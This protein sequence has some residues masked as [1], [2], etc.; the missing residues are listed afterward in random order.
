MKKISLFLSLTTAILISLSPVVSA[1]NS[2]TNISI[3]PEVQ[4]NFRSNYTCTIIMKNFEQLYDFKLI[5]KDKVD[6]NKIVTLQEEIS[7]LQTQINA[8]SNGEDITSKRE[9]LNAKL[10]EFNRLQNAAN[11]TNSAKFTCATKNLEGFLKNPNQT[12][13]CPANIENPAFNE[14]DILGCSIITGRIRFAYLPRFIVYSLDLL[15][16]LSGVVS[17]LFVILGGYF[18]LINGISGGDT[19]KGKTY[20][21]NALIGLITS[22]SAWAVINLIQLV[23]T[24]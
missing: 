11:P 20:I 17:L 5:T 13:Y 14:N 1:N 15:T 3:I 23:L 18:Y 2:T 9:E 21:K 4:E 6:P 19:E 8:E 10:T 22:L 7:S 12:F 24:S 16:L